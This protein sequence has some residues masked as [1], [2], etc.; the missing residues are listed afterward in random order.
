MWCHGRKELCNNQAYWFQ[1]RNCSCQC[2][3]GRG[4]KRKCVE[5]TFL[6]AK[7]FQ[8]DEN[9]CHI[10]EDT[11]PSESCKSHKDQPVCS[12]RGVCICGKCLCHKIKFGKVYG[13]YCE[14]DDFSCPYHHGNL[15]AGE[16]KYVHAVIY[17]IVY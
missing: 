9:K 3:D 12:G 6:D 7:C 13:K 17:I 5:E 11:F 15:C 16:Y 10:D 4:P 8:C 2:D 1:H 14:K